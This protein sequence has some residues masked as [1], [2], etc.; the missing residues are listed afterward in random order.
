MSVGILGIPVLSVLK[1]QLKLDLKVCHLLRKVGG[2]RVRDWGSVRQ[3][4]RA[5]VEA[6][7]RV[8]RANSRRLRDSVVD[9]KLRGREKVDPIVLMVRA[10]VPK[11]GLEDLVPIFR[12]AVSLGMRGRRHFDLGTK[13]PVKLLPK[14][15]NELDVTVRDDRV[16]KTVVAIDTIQV[17]LGVETCGRVTVQARANRCGLAL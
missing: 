5:G 12:L 13:K 1:L 16:R 17:K 10:E 14:A 3:W 9:G 8:E 2:S 7:V 6:I 11:V 4:V 15:R